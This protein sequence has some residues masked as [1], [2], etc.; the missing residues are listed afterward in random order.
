VLLSVVGI[1]GRSL[2]TLRLVFKSLLSTNP[3][4]QDPN[5]VP[6]LFREDSEIFQS[7]LLVTT[8]H[9]GSWSAMGKFYLT[10]QSSTHFTYLKKHCKRQV[11]MLE[12]LQVQNPGTFLG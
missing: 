8:P 5:I 9:S 3:W 10:L 12:S 1:L 2:P 6:L 11:M 7:E 4:L